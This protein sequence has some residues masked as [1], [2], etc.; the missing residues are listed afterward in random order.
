MLPNKVGKAANIPVHHN[1]A[2]E[3]VEEF[4]GGFKKFKMGKTSSFAMAEARRV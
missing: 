4:G 1:A 2:S 3:Y